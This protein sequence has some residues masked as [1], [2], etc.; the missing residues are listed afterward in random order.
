MKN[1]YLVLFI[2]LLT[3]GMMNCKQ[4]S[5]ESRDTAMSGT[6]NESSN[7]RRWSK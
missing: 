6:D 7:N 5:T 2:L 3:L 1:T 4:K